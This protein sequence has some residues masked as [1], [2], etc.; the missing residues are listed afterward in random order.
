MTGYFDWYVI[1]NVAC[2][3]PI[4]WPI[5]YNNFMASI[6]IYKSDICF[7]VVKPEVTIFLYGFCI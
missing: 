5:S 3:M 2:N 1:V 7:V 4:I 6:L